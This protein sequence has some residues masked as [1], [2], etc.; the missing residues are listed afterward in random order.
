MLSQHPSKCWPMSKKKRDSN[1]SWTSWEKCQIPL[2][3]TSSEGVSSGTQ[4]RGSHL[5]KVFNMNGLSRACLQTSFFIILT[6]ILIR[7]E[8]I[9]RQAL[10]SSILTPRRRT[11]LPNLRVT[12]WSDNNL[13]G[14]PIKILD[15]TTLIISRLVIWKDKIETSMAKTSNN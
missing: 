13:P 10:L 3:S 8:T 5:M 12:R 9:T 15:K 7:A 14:D 6:T 11:A 1:T 4:R 2:S